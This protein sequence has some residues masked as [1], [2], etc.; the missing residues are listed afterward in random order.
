MNHLT[1]PTV[2][3]G[4]ANIVTYAHSTLAQTRTRCLPWIGWNGS[5]IVPLKSS[6]RTC[7]AFSFIHQLLIEVFR[8]MPLDLNV[9]S[10]ALDVVG[11]LACKYDV[12][13][14]DKMVDS[15]DRLSLCPEQAVRQ[16]KPEGKK[17]PNTNPIHISNFDSERL[18]R[19]DRLNR[20]TTGISTH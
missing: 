1:C 15:R 13:T 3:K 14:G 2:W 12:S 18:T 11:G 8:Y 16:C 17:L 7:Y 10:S 19:K 6:A 4:A 5:R 9:I 20:F